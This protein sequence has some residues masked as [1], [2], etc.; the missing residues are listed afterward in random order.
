MKKKVCILTNGK[1]IIYQNGFCLR[2][3][4]VHHFHNHNAYKYVLF[5]IHSNLKIS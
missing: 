3:M 4:Q 5:K 2:E 1:V